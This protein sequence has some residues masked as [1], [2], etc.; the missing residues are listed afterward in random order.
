MTLSIEGLREKL[1]EPAEHVIIRDGDRDLVFE[2][3]M[4]GRGDYVV[5]TIVRIYATIGGLIV[6]HTERIGYPQGEETTDSAV[7]HDTSAE[8]L[9]W[10][11]ADCGGQL[12]VASKG[13]WQEACYRWPAIE[14]ERDEMVV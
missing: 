13:A 1:G 11:R 7:A 4:V 5:T 2:G 10:L 8:A 14:N 9:D 6:T 3:W 12:G